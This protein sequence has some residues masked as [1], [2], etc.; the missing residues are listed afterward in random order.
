MDF[1]VHHEFGLHSKQ[2]VLDKENTNKISGDKNKIEYW[3]ETWFRY[4]TEVHKQFA[5]KKGFYFFDYNSFVRDPESS[6]AILLKVLRISGS[7]T[8][9]LTIKK[10]SLKNSEKENVI[11]EKYI[12]LFNKLSSIAINNHDR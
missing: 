1:L 7:L 2:P 5:Y 9:E 11:Q 4:Y 3:I 12:E 8:K 6:L 10:F